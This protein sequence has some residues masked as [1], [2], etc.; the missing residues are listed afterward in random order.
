MKK[1]ATV[2]FMV[3]FG[4]TC[5]A[6]NAKEKLTDNKMTTKFDSVVDNF[7]SAFMNAGPRVGISIGIIKDGSSLIYNYGTT[8]KGKKQLPAG[9]S[10]Y[11]LASITKTFS[12]ALLAKAIIDKKVKL[13]DD[14]RLYLDGKYPNLAYNG[15]PIKLVNLANLTS[16]LPNWMPDNKDLFSKA[17]PDSIA[18]I[19][20]AIHKKYSRA[21]LYRDLHSVKLDTVPG[22]VTRHCNTAAQLLGYV[23]ERVY[24]AP[25]D[26]LFEQYFAKPLKM[27]N[28]TFLSEGRLPANLA[29]GYDG[30]G[31]IMPF[32]VWDDLRVAASLASTANDMLKYMAYQMDE[33]NPDVLLSHQPTNGT[34]DKGAIALNWKV[35]MTDKGIRKFS[36]TGGSLG[37]SSYIVFY[38]DKKTGIV[39]LTNEADP[40]AQGALI[41]LADNIIKP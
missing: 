3:L 18:D 8:V 9:N 7:V 32:V 40:A 24:G 39:L 36:H 4:F 1:V 22:A 30:K 41:N 38:P 23:M 10:V 27:K 12:S 37:F 31:R 33:K 26:K 17:N 5:S 19:L 14:I 20:D 13:N 11:E 28:S 15:I 35:N 34:P 29:T 21:Q 2:L 6:Q 25:I 16:G